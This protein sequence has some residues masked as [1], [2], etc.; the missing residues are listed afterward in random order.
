MPDFQRIAAHTSADDTL[1][2]AFCGRTSR[3]G[4]DLIAA[5]DAAIC[6]EC[7]AACVEALNEPATD[8]DAINEQP[9]ELA[10]R[11][12]FFRL[13]GDADVEQLLEMDALVDVMEQTIRRL[14]GGASPQSATAVL[15]LA[16]GRIDCATAYAP[17]DGAE[18]AVLGTQLTSAFD[19][20]A[21][22]GLPS[23]LETLLLLSPET[24]AILAVVGGRYLAHACTAAMSALSAR[25][26]ARDDASRLTILGPA[27]VARPHLE[28]LESVFELSGV[29]IWSPTAEDQEAL[30]DR[31]ESNLDVQV[32]RSVE[33]AVR[34]ADLLVIAVPPGEVTVRPDW[35]ADGTH[36]MIAGLTISDARDISTTLAHRGR[37]FVEAGGLATGQNAVVMADVAGKRGDGRRSAREVT[38]FESVGLTIEHVAA[39]HVVFQK[40]VTTDTG[41][42]LEL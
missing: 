40:G 16:G 12:A 6:D 14:S 33:D 37:L 28:A 9:D 39:A 30:L 18:P 11:R 38:I 5:N 7:A 3:D 24:G 25:L 42:E 1:T 17:A 22:V 4:R 27:T 8:D 20:N 10:G 13:L 19:G 41:R 29:R 31:L 34:A 32:A 21:V 15:A 35:I 26:L 23:T 2:C 36:V